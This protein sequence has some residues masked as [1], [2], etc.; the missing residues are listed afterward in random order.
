MLFC[1]PKNDIVSSLA[2]LPRMIDGSSLY[3]LALTGVRAKM[4]EF[5]WRRDGKEV[6]FTKQ[7]CNKKG[8]VRDGLMK[9]LM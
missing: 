9:D 6:D 1:C 2:R 3:A 7:K 5:G 4:N 8:F